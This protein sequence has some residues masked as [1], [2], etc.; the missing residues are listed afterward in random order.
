MD[1]RKNQTDK[2][3][4]YI[5]ENISVLNLKIR[6]IALLADCGEVSTEGIFTLIPMKKQNTEIVEIF[7]RNHYNIIAGSNEYLTRISPL[8]VFFIHRTDLIIAIDGDDIFLHDL[9]RSAF[10]SPV[11]FIDSFS[12]ALLWRID[13]KLRY[14]MKNE[15]GLKRMKGF[16]NLY[17]NSDNEKKLYFIASVNNGRD[18]ILLDG[19]PVLKEERILRFQRANGESFAVHK[20]ILARDMNL[21][22]HGIVNGRM[23]RN[24]CGFVFEADIYRGYESVKKSVH[25][26]LNKFS[27][28]KS[29]K[30]SEFELRLNPLFK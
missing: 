21:K 8:E 18:G 23:E 7:R 28:E 15:V 1:V 2:L 3:S 22:I 19:M 26:Y 30:I 10:N 25:D 29:L 14:R 20:D 16:E 24:E 4:K 12:G 5:K 11:L 6:S 13:K 9:Y 17:Y 27:D